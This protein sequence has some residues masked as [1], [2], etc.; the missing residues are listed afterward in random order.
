MAMDEKTI[1][2]D[3]KKT[4][5]KCA[6]CYQPF[7]FTDFTAYY[8]KKH[9]DSVKCL[10]CQKPSFFV[11]PSANTVRAHI[12]RILV[13]LIG[14]VPALLGLGV[15]VGFLMGE[16]RVLPIWLV[17]GGFALSLIIIRYLM[18]LVRWFF[19]STETSTFER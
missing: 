16:G 4:R 11:F 12:A 1:G 2:V 9:A 7:D 5:K 6:H 17:L 3:V 19:Y 14:G 18:R 10:H 13:Y 15:L 8:L